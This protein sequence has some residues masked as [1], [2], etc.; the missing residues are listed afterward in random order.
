MDNSLKLSYDMLFEN[1]PGLEEAE[2]DT[3][4]KPQTFTPDELQS[5]LHQRDTEWEKR[6][7]EACAKARKQGFEEG[8]A[9]GKQQA[10]EKFTRQLSGIEEMMQEVDREFNRAMDELKPHMAGLVFD[11]TEKVL[12]VPFRHPEMQQRVEDEIALLVENLDAE[13]HIKVTVAKA[14]FEIIKKAFDEYGN[15]DHFTLR[16]DEDHKPGEYAV[17]TKKESIIKNFKKMVADFKESVSFAEVD[18]LQL[19]S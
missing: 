4:P 12:D 6:L 19:E 5:Q 18:S 14:D 9:Q 1:N 7:E 15:M 16:V 13:L 10:E 8:L 3:T 17:E 2:T 11:M